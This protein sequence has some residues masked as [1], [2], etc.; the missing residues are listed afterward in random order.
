MHKQLRVELRDWLCETNI[1]LHRFKN[2]SQLVL[3]ALYDSILLTSYCIFASFTQPEGYN[4]FN[5]I[6]VQ[7][8]Y[9]RIGQQNHPV[10][11]WDIPYAYGT[12]Y[13]Y[14]TEQY[15]IYLQLQLPFS[16]I[17]NMPFSSSYTSSLTYCMDSSKNI[18][19]LPKLFKSACIQLHVFMCF[20]IKSDTSIDNFV[21][22]ALVRHNFY[23]P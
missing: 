8:T 20:G 14:R 6:R 11:I 5:S 22:V 21:I 18:L 7:D 9:T 2:Y 15:S 10:R 4:Y 17:Q 23:W 1:L 16:N 13:A 19:Q 12:K 3:L